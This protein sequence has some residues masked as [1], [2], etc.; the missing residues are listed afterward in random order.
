MRGHRES[1]LASVLDEPIQARTRIVLGEDPF[2]TPVEVTQPL[3]RGPSALAHIT[4]RLHGAPVHDS[5]GSALAEAAAKPKSFSGLP[6]RAQT[7]P[8]LLDQ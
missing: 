2:R 7:I 6:P 4:L 5:Y 1:E 3:S 8:W